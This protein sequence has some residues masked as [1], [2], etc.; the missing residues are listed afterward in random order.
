MNINTPTTTATATATTTATA[1]TD[2]GIR[3]D[4][5]AHQIVNSPLDIYN[6]AV[7]QAN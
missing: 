6:T 5:I 7:Q 4:I 2:S 3:L 1:A